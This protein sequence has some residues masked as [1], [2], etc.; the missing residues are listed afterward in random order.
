MLMDAVVWF[1]LLTDV[2]DSLALGI[3][4]SVFTKRERERKRRNGEV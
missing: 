1:V 2:P 3:P 4:G